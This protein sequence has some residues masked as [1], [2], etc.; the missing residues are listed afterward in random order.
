MISEVHLI[1][2]R[3]KQSTEVW[4]LSGCPPTPQASQQ[5]TDRIGNL[6]WVT[7]GNQRWCATY[8]WWALWPGASCSSLLR[9]G[10]GFYQFPFLS[11]EHLQCTFAVYPDFFEFHIQPI[12]RLCTSLVLCQLRALLFHRFQ[13]SATF[14]AASLLSR[15]KTLSAPAH[16]TAH[17]KN[18]KRRPH[19]LVSFSRQEKHMWCDT[20][21]LIGTLEVCP[22]PYIQKCTKHFYSK[23]GVQP[24]LTRP[25]RG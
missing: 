16:W 13:P 24:I 7:G 15:C 22:P 20:L 17:H 23:P 8:W 3:S 1:E 9:D 11:G 21:L 5:R 14:A 4:H 10:R 2:V 25:I 12:P 6:S 18:T 19:P